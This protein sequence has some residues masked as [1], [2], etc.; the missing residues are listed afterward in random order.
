MNKCKVMSLV[1]LSGLFLQSSVS[2]LADT[3]VIGDNT[4]PVVTEVTSGIVSEVTESQP[5][6]TEP[7]TEAPDNTVIGDNTT[8]AVTTESGSGI[9]SEV[10]TKGTESV[11][12][13]TTTVTEAETSKASSG[14]VTEDTGLVSETNPI[15]TPVRTNTGFKIVDTQNGFVIVETES[16]QREVK[17]VEEVGGKVR[18]D[19]KL[20]VK[21]ET[22][23]LKVLP[24]TGEVS[25]ILSFI[26]KVLVVL[27]VLLLVFREKIKIALEKRKASRD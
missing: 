2:V 25:G 17:T 1:L 10:T 24:S 6:V 4:A 15:E 13:A 22:N 27:G 19:G 23:K 26:G 21:D 18:E 3:T 11:T 7:V 5:V 9:V 8:P 16:G 14:Q 12:E 20:E